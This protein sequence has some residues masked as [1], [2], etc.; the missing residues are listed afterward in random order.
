MEQNEIEKYLFENRKIAIRQMEE[1]DLVGREEA[2]NCNEDQET[3]Y[4]A[5]KKARVNSS[6]NGEGAAVEG[7]AAAGRPSFQKVTSASSLQSSRRSKR[8]R[9]CKGDMELYVSSFDTIKKLKAQVMK[10]TLIF[11][12]LEKCVWRVFFLPKDLLG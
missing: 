1:E 5:S 6:V 12:N 2:A 8:S 11:L 10:K 9:K 4:V 7:G 3:V